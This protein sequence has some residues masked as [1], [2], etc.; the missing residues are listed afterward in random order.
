MLS[1]GLRIEDF[2][3]R[4]RVL[5]IPDAQAPCRKSLASM[6]K[7]LRPTALQTPP[8]TNKSGCQKGVTSAR[9]DR[10]TNARDLQPETCGGR[11]P[12]THTYVRTH[13]LTLSI[14][15]L[16]PNVTNPEPLTVL[17]WEANVLRDNVSDAC[18]H[19][20]L[21]TSSLVERPEP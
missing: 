4:A 15:E 14:L 19:G 6:H 20:H 18:Q 2:K 10:L 13:T 12:H 11:P 16:N 7:A 21:G 17:A 3:K 9:D 5:R 1:L 8:N